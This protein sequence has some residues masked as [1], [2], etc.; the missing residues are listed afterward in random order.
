MNNIQVNYRYV[1]ISIMVLLFG[2]SAISDAKISEVKSFS[3]LQKSIETFGE[4]NLNN[5]LLVM[6]DDD[7][8]TMMKCTDQKDANKFIFPMFFDY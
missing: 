4:I 3:E 5:T 8:L 1:I 6:D 2:T 7:T